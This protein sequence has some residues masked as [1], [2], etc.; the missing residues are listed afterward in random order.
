MNV[1]NSMKVCGLRIICVLLLVN[2]SGKAVY[3]VYTADGGFTDY[4]GYDNVPQLI[5]EWLLLRN[6]LNYAIPSV[7]FISGVKVL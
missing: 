2:Q 5:K 7:M 1:E 3:R 6:S 4:Q